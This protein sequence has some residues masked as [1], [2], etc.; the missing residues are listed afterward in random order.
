M[1]RDEHTLPSQLEHLPS[2]APSSPDLSCVNTRVPRPVGIVFPPGTSLGWDA[3]PM[4]ACAVQCAG[5]LAAPAG[6]RRAAE[7]PLPG[8]RRSGLTMLVAKV[9]GQPW[10]SFGIEL[11]LSF[12]PTSFWFR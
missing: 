9:P 2:P 4:G 8:A 6:P 7:A 11:A 5:S 3:G 10:S 12:V 1:H